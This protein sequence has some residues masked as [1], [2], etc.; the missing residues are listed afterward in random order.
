MKYDLFTHLYHKIIVSACYLYIAN[1]H[2]AV[3]H[4]NWQ[5]CKFTYYEYNR[6]GNLHF[7]I[8]IQSTNII[9]FGIPLKVGNTIVFLL[10]THS[11]RSGFFNCIF[12]RFLYNFTNS[13]YEVNIIHVLKSILVIPM[14]FVIKYRLFCRRIPSSFSRC[15]LL[16]SSIN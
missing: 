10:N 11:A 4:L 5:K 3:K 8:T 9:Y 15:D 6:N 1:F 2:S 12:F 14:Y 16:Y 13:T 7:S